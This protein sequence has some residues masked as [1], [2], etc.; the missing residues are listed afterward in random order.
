MITKG[1]KK[2]TTRFSVAPG[3]GVGKVYLAGDFNGWRPQ[4][5]RRQK[6]GSFV[7]IV[8]LPKG[9]HEYKFLLDGKWMTDP[10]HGAWALNAHGT[11][12]SVA[13]VE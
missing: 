7:K 2:G 9:A 3:E 11:M 13:V 4:A 6:D 10:D 1:H 5:M 8:S 12:N